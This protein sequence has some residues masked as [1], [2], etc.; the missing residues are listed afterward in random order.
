MRPDKI[1]IGL[2]L[3]TLGS[4]IKILV[5]YE[6]CLIYVGESLNALSQPFILNAAAKLSSTWFGTRAVSV[7]ESP[8]QRNVATTIGILAYILG[9]GLGYYLPAVLLRGHAE[10]KESFQRLFMLQTTVGL[11]VFILNAIL[12]RSRPPK[13]PHAESGRR[14]DTST[15]RSIVRLFKTSNYL[16]LSFSFMCSVSVLLAFISL[17]YDLCSM[18]LSAGHKYQVN[19]IFLGSGIVAAL[20]LSAFRCRLKPTLVALYGLSLA[21]LLALFVAVSRASAVTL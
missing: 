2:T 3:A 5:N 10:S 8:P 15:M 4:G 14:Y 16:L 9:I 7:R 18:Y 11:A 17:T 6:F 1:I 21:V 19:C 12:F 13:P 20:T